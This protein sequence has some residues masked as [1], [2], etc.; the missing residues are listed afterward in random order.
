MRTRSALGF[1][2]PL[3]RRQ[4][5]L[6]LRELARAAVERGGLGSELGSVRGRALGRLRL[7]CEAEAVGVRRKSRRRI[8]L[9]FRTR[10]RIKAL[11]QPLERVEVARALA[12]RS[13]SLQCCSRRVSYPSET[14]MERIAVC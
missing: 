3:L 1:E 2:H 8:A 12:I 10:R 9:G 11:R 13:A 14:S 7:R 6:A 5:A 4:L